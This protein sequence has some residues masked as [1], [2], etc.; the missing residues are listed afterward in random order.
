MY[1]TGLA[2]WCETILL[3]FVRVQRVLRSDKQP[4][5]DPAAPERNSSAAVENIWTMFSGNYTSWPRI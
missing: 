5:E 4:G 1:G 2:E 3:G